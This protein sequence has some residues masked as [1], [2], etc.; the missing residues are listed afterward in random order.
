MKKLKVDAI[1][2]GTVIDH[3]P[4]GRV[5]R[6]L[7]ILGSQ[8]KDVAMIGMN[9]SSQ[10]MG[11]K[12]I[13]KIEGRELTPDEVNSIALIAPHAKVN[14]IR[15]FK[16]VKKGQVE[17]P[18]LIVGLMRCPNPNCITNHE[19]I[20]SRFK[21]LKPEPVTLCCDYCERTYKAEEMESI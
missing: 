15:D 10:A 6:V 1:R 2:N 3:I 7:D 13:I 11:K 8:E 4:A 19:P 12:D 21:V 17:I 5:L 16:V 18:E 9:F 14:I 20:T